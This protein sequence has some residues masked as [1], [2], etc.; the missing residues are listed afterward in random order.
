MKHKI[1]LSL[2]TTCVMLLSISYAQNF[3]KVT[4]GPV[5]TSPGDSRSVNWVDVNNDDLPDLMITN[6]P[7]GGQ[8]NFLYLNDA[9][10]G[11]IAVT[12]DTIVHDSKPSDGATWADTDNDGD[13]D[14]FV[15][16]WYNSIGLYYTGNGNGTFVYQPGAGLTNGI[17]YSETAAWG[18][19]DQDG[20]V[21]LYV[22]RSGG[23][24]ATN[25]NFLF[26]NNAGNSFTK[27]TVGTP[28]TDAAVSRSVNWTDI[29]GDGDLD[30]FVTNEGSSNNNEH[31][32]RN[33]SA[34]QFV[35]LTSGPLLNDG[36]S[37]MSSS[38][39]DFDNDG[40]LDVF[41][42][43]DNSTNGLFRNDGN[44]V[45]N[46]LSSDTVSTTP[47]NSFSSAWADVDNDGDLDLFVTNAF[48]AN[49]KLP[50]FFYLNNGN[51]TFSRIAN[52]T[53]VQDSGWTYGCAFAD[54]DKDGFQDLAV[55]T[56][57]YQGVD[58]VDNL[59]HNQGNTNNWIS[60][61]LIGSQSNR[62]AIG[63]KVRVKA[64]INGTFVWQLREISAQS[65]Y[66]GQNELRGHFGLGDASLIDSLKIEWPSGLVSYF[67]SIGI[68]QFI[69][70]TEGQGL[71]IESMEKQQNELQCYPNP[72]NE[73]ITIR[74]GELNLQPGDELVFQNSKGD[75]LSRINISHTVNE[76]T[77]D[78][79][80]QGIQAKGVYY[81]THISKSKKITKKILKL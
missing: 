60:I 50:C 3:S 41:L 33:D 44:F 7:A 51:S 19:Y 4:S 65:S 20:Y 42:A 57:R 62:S 54:Y 21:D 59:Y 25:R 81:V 13:L 45:F 64:N 32:Y 74:T 11:F 76:I 67:D 31:M 29:D 72:G 61:K 49:T 46:K 79:K 30:L 77:I 80:Q 39:G 53:L 66:C 52:H 58:A 1:I 43:N 10:G 38:W 14:C 27:I 6:G 56:C 28:T 26:H 22:A 2:T 35:K 63:S 5:V 47:S 78:L 36:K 55:A 69:T 17:T 9:Q 24:V 18:D 34:G 40:D 73:K 12:N 71:T 75:T 23:T 15:A 37:T 16:N 48:A 70:I 8:N 68:N